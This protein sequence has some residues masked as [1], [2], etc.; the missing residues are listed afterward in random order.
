MIR[1]RTVFVPGQYAKYESG[2]IWKTAKDS[3]VAIDGGRLAADIAAACNELDRAGYE[4]VSVFPLT[5]G[6]AIMQGA[7]Q[8]GGGAGWA[9]TFGAIVVARSAD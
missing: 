3:N 9:L 6:D 4:T 5:R 8:G 1:Y 7:S 2:W